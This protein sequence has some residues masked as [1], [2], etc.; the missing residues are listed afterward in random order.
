VA[1][2]IDDETGVAGS[3]RILLSLIRGSGNTNQIG[4]SDMERHV[5]NI[6][7]GGTLLIRRAQVA[8]RIVDLRIA[9][10]VLQMAPQL[11][12][13]DSDVGTVEA[14]G[15][16]LL[17]GLHDHHIHLR[18]AAAARQ[19]VA[20]DQAG[21]R[22][23]LGV[24][25]QQAPGQG[26]IRAAG[27]HEATAGDLDRDDLDALCPLRPLRLQHS[28]GKLWVLN[29]A[30]IEALGL[31]TATELPGVER[32]AHGRVTGRLW[33]MD[34]WLHEHLPASAHP[35]LAELSTA[36]AGY[37]I[38]GVTDASYNNTAAS[39]ADFDVAASR[40][41]L[42]QHVL[43][44]GN[45]SLPS[46][47]LK[48]LLDE[49]DLPALPELVAGIQTAAAQGRGVAF[50]CVSHIELLFALQALADAG[51]PE[52]ARIEH[53]GVVRAEVVR[54]L[55]SSAVTVV[56]QPG[57][58][59]QRGERFRMQADAEDVGYL[60]PYGTLLAAGVPVAASSDAPYGPLD[61]WQ[62]MAAAVNRRTESGRT[63]GVRECVPAAE[64]LR[65]YLADPR[66]P[67]GPARRVSMGAPAD[68]CL[69][70]RSLGAALEDL[71]AVQVRHTWINGRLV[72]D[73]SAS[74]SSV[75]SPR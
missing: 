55:K 51:H 29:S 32:D 57:F 39:A 25:L 47:T 59:A 68:L 21:D 62:I 34:E 28:S 41:E 74:T 48:I 6:P 42:L 37:G 4:G 70:D 33:R 75:C 13:V 40:G 65:G 31:Q 72:Y 66:A 18:A 71:A 15:A 14:D 17:P 27:Y 63:L 19:S 56:T 58:I 10:V 30:A 24:L 26:W 20:C 12:R 2:Q 69:L 53:A 52:G 7:S 5:T 49:D 67:G 1:A 23:G 22:A 54:Q 43:L 11:P 35:Q 9:D 44:M 60:Y 8:G 64:A 46:G 73:S 38:T 45:A 61:P 36:L 16:A 50:H 3:G